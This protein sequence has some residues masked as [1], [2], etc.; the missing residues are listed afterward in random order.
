MSGD[1]VTME[2][3][4]GIGKTTCSTHGQ[5]VLVFLDEL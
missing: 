5:R 2:R 1:A 3:E 4:E